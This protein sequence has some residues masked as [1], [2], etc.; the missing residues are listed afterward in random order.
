M[1]FK[2]FAPGVLTA[3]DVNTFLMRQAVITCT[4]TT[5]PASPTEGMTIYETDTD[6]FRFYTGTAW[7]ELLTTEYVPWTPAWT[8]R[9][10]TNPGAPSTTFNPGDGTWTGGYIKI[11]TFVY[12]WGTYTFGTGWVDAATGEVLG[13]TKPF[14]VQTGGS[15]G[16]NNM[17][18]EYLLQDSSAGYTWTGKLDNSFLTLAAQAELFVRQ[19]G[20][21]MATT[22]GGYSVN[23]DTPWPFAPDNAP[24]Y[25]FMQGWLRTA[26]NA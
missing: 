6:D 18:G 21:V 14:A 7:R 26:V 17:R 13:V 25:F 22:S 20:F 2:T 15:T 4:S 3:A 9:L 5:R 1:P 11:G 12:Y 24:D 16:G 8:A 10:G 19:D 23:V